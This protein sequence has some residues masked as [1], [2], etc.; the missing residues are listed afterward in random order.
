MKPV[1]KQ[2]DHLAESFDNQAVRPQV[3]GVLVACGRCATVGVAGLCG[4]FYRGSARGRLA[5]KGA[6]MPPVSPVAR[7]AGR[8]FQPRHGLLVAITAIVVGVVLQIFGRQT[9]VG[10]ERK[11]WHAPNIRPRHNFGRFK[12]SGL[13][14][15]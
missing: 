1:P 4:S 9:S 14:P 2:L 11:V 10:Q 13:Q 3:A 15:R 12:D 6:G 8:V 7:R 5:A